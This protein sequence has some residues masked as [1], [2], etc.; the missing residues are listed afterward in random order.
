M[1]NLS[2]RPDYNT[3]TQLQERGVAANLG[4]VMLERGWHSWKD[5]ESK[6]FLLRVAW[7]L[8]AAKAIPRPG[9]PAKRSRSDGASQLLLGYMMGEDRS[10]MNRDLAHFCGKDALILEL[11]NKQR[12]AIGCVNRYSQHKPQG[13]PLPSKENSLKTNDP[14]AL[15][16]RYGEE[17][18]DAA[19]EGLSGA[20]RV[21]LWT[22]DENIPMPIRC[23]CRK[24][25]MKL[26][27]SSNCMKCGGKGYTLDPERKMGANARIVL[28]ALQLKGIVEF[29]KLDMTCAEIGDLCGMC[30]NT[31][32]EILDQWED[33]KVLQIIPGKVTYDRAGAVVDREP[34]RIV[35]LPGL[36]LD[37]GIVEREE[38]RFAVHLA[39][40][41]ELAKLN[42]W[43][44]A[45][46]HLA[47]IAALHTELLRRWHMSRHSL[48]AFW[49]AMRKLI[50][51]EGLP[52]GRRPG[53]QDSNHEP[54]YRAYLFP[55]HLRE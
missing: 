54:D 4:T 6:K 53:L 47:R 32:A 20:G 1:A 29:G 2:R 23:G 51:R 10:T 14:A 13:E 12:P 30:V 8:P 16:K 44:M 9:D 49:T 48:G 17:Y 40:T 26:N 22:F 34:Q 33:L 28:I 24:G 15:A 3:P 39:R 37:S 27:F 21:A 11:F 7:V 25:Q 50:W 18:F 19:V 36:L 42:G 41:L 5:K 31:V 45:E 52:C 38:E 43:S 35:W 46:I 55:F